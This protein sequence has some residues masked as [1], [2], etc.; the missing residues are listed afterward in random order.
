MKEIDR[1][2]KQWIPVNTVV[3]QEIREAIVKEIKETA[4]EFYKSQVRGSTYWNEEKRTFDA[5]ILYEDFKR[6]KQG[7]ETKI[8]IE[9]DEEYAKRVTP[10]EGKEYVKDILNETITGALSPDTGPR[11]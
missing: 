3:R 7:G 9:T 10:I 4:V 6:T 8:H 11:S 5:K 1:L 2:L